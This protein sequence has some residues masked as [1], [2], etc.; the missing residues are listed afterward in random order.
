MRFYVLAQRGLPSDHPS[1]RYAKILYS[2]VFDSTDEFV[3][4]DVQES[5][6]SGQD[7]G[8]ANSGVVVKGRTTGHPAQVCGQFVGQGGEDC[9]ALLLPQQATLPPTWTPH[10]C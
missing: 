5:P 8:S 7:F 4:A 1:R 10:V 3:K 2:L 9:P 6:R